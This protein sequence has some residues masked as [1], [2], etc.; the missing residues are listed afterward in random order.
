MELLEGETLKQR[1][2]RKPVETEALL[3]IA[4]GVADALD[5][6]HAAGI[7]HRDIKPANIHITLRG[8]A[9]ILDFGLAKICSTEALSQSA[10][11]TANVSDEHLTSPSSAL[12]TVAYM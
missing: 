8:R 5:T 4:I 2:S 9:K 7:V 10:M 6:A 11:P 1:I 3:E 12:G